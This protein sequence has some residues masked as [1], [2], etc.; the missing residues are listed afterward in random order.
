MDKRT[1]DEVQINVHIIGI[2]MHQIYHYLQVDA[3]QAKQN[4][5]ETHDLEL[6][7]AAAAPPP[8]RATDD[9]FSLSS[10]SVA[11]LQQAFQ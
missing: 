3:K 10:F 11:F 4:V 1:L 7:L 5:L 8:L 9:A 2:I 6:S